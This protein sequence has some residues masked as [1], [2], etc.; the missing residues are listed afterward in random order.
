M[1]A[2]AWNILGFIL[3]YV[4]NLLKRQKLKETIITHGE[5]LKLL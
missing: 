4:P 2:L 5:V 3:R 1:K